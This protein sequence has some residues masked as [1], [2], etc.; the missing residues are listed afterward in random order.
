MT[1]VVTENCIQCR[2]TDCVD[3]CPVDAFHIGPNFIAINPRECIDCALCVPEC[4]EEAIVPDTALHA[5]NQ[6]FLALNAALA[7]RWPVILERLAPL[8][9]HAEWHGRSDRLALLEDRPVQ[10]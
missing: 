3:I 7:Q 8:P 1:H 6:Q 2:H 5:G 10:D 4:P 9:E